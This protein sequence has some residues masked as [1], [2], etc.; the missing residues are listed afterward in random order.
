MSTAAELS[1]RG[2]DATAGRPGPARWAT[3]RARRTHSRGRIAAAL[4]RRAVRTL[5]I[6]VALPGRPRAR[7]G[8][9]RTRPS[10][11]STGRAPSSTGSA[12]TSR[13]A[14][15]RRTWR[16]TG[17]A[18]TLAEVLTRSPTRLADPRPAAVADAAP[19]RRATPA[20]DR[21][22]RPSSGARQNIH[23]HYDLSNDLFAHVPRRDDDVLLAR[24]SRPAW[25]TSPT[26]SAARSTACWTTPASAADTHVLEIGTGWGA[27]AIR[28]ARA[29]RGS[30][31]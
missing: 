25:T 8:R 11:G 2:G 1:A 16:G 5:P 15:A 6:R 21:G 7:C 9:R 4:F 12:P 10:C 29:G 20:R 19:A 24:C 27:L 3:S 31:R 23:R 26:P 28:A 18:T 17:P 13:S 30:R 22:Q 14:S